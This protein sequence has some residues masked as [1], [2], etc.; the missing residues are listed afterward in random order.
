M[1]ELLLNESA[2]PEL[3]AIGSLIDADMGAFYMWLDEQRLP[4]ANHSSFLAWFEDHNQALVVGPNL[5]ANTTSDQS[6]D[7][8]WLLKQVTT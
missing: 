6:V 5:P 8:R 2:N 3:D 4:G 1:N 7:M